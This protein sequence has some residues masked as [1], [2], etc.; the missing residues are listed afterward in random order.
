MTA[1]LDKQLIFVTGKGG[2]GKTTTAAA[3][4]RLAA[5]RGKRAL[6]CEIDTDPAM[7]RLFGDQRIGF[8]PT[9]IGEG[10][11]A[12]NLTA[13]DCTTAFM[14]RFLPS[15]RIADLVLKNKVA[16]LFFESAPSVVEAVILDQLATLAVEHELCFDTIVVD[17]PASGHAVTFLKVPKSMARMVAVGDLAEHL[18]QLARLISDPSRTEIVVVTLPEE[19]AV[20]E[21][22]ELWRKLTA[23]V[24]TPVRT[25]I[26]NG[27]RA[28]E[29]RPHDLDTID[30]LVQAVGP[31]GAPAFAKLADAVNLGL[32]WHSEDRANIDRLGRG[33]DG[34][35]ITVPFV[36]DKES[37]SD[38]V[39]RMAAALRVLL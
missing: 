31:S 6:I 5:E 29:L 39:G 37:D 28:P 3:L 12:C 8:E 23:T 10:I 18:R 36:F 25:V 32:Y 19:M 9:S 30:R 11:Y 34:R 24:D 13:S 33:I 21:S 7:G 35:V 26:V 22:L 27:E 17:L 38:L 20:N 16:Q 15:R 1:L 14:H 2:V 4:G